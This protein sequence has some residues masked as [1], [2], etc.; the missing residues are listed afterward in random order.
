[1]SPIAKTPG[2][3]GL[4]RSGIDRHEIFVEVETPI[5][6]RAEFHGEPEKRDQPLARE[7]HAWSPLA[8]P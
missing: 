2:H 3:I 5:G 4:E 1:M 6:D 7:F 8:C